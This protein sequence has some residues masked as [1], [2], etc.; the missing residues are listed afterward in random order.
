MRVLGIETS[1]DETGV[2]V[3]DTE[4]GLLAHQ[5]YSQVKLHADY[6]GVVPELASRDHVR[7]TLPL[8]KAALKEA[9]ISHQQLD[10]IAYTMGPGLVGALL[11]G[12]CIGRSLA[13][14]WNLPAVGVH[15]MEGHLLAPMLEENQPEFPFVALL[16]SG[17][18][19]QLVQVK[20]I[21]DYHLLGESVDDAAG[22]AFDKTAKLMGLDYPGGPR[23]AALA[24]QG[25]SDRFTFPRPMTDRPGLNFSFSGLKTSAANTLAA[26]DSDEQTLADIARAFEDAVVDTLVIKCR[27]ALKETGYKRLVVA[28]GVS[29]NKHLRAKL[30]ALLEKQKGQIFYPRT[31]FCTDNGAMIALAGALRLEAGEREPLAVKT[32]PRWPMTD[33]KPMVN[34]SDAV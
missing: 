25:N 6:G 11:V 31:E 17:G 33:L 30:E 22:E 28:G 32:H 5:L 23:L 8:I 3:Y 29:A 27:R 9:G 20:G 34:I 2:A 4:K 12:A 21:G 7:K 18:H 16:V 13:F 1:C 14:G 15:H 26:N 10:G 24:E 19:T